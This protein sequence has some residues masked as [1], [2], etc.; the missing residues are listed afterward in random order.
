MKK[1]LIIAALLL[2]SLSIKAN[3]TIRIQRKQVLEIVPEYK[4]VEPSHFAIV[5]VQGKRY[6][7][8]VTKT[9]LKKID[10]AKELFLVEL[11]SYTKLIAK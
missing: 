10:T 11:K 1:T 7:V 2:A 6:I 9:E 4:S 3:D 8:K 5:E